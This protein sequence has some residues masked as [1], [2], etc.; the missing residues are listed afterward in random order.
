MKFKKKSFRGFRD[1]RKECRS[2][3]ENLTV[4]QMCKTT[5]LK[6]KGG[7]VLKLRNEPVKLKE[8]ETAHKHCTVVDNVVSL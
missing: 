2:L 1:P 5:S 8:K 3:Q 6:G 4:L 7:M